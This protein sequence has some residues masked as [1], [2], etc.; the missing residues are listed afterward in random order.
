[1]SDWKLVPISSSLTQRRAAEHLDFENHTDVDIALL[2]AQ[3]LWLPIVERHAYA[4]WR[5]P[6]LFSRVADLQRAGF[7]VH[8]AWSG[9]RPGA[10]KNTADGYMAKGIVETLDRHP[11]I[12]TVIIVSGD[13]Y[14][15]PLA[16]QL[17][18]QGITV[19]VA[20]DPLR[21]SHD[22]LR[23]ADYYLP[24]GRLAQ[25]T[26]MLDRLERSSRYLTFSFVLQHS[27]IRTVD[28]E[29]MIRRGFVVQEEV[30][31]PHRG[32]RPEL[33]LNRQTY[34]VAAVL[35]VVAQ[36]APSALIFNGRW[37]D[38]RA[39]LQYAGTAA[40][41]ARIVPDLPVCD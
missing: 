8:Q 12:T 33:R 31:R 13:V 36:V 24:L 40:R 3:L 21:A 27:P 23:I 14:F 26:I 1:M 28:L 18:Q 41:P 4:D 30:D 32:T 34:V 7:M 2:Q 39:Y 15:V 9:R 17:R 25:Q 20:S 16:R 29:W 19:I 38:E 35:D 10:R 11:E 5:N 6:G 22:L 37:Y